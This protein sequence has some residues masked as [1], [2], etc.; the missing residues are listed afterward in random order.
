[1]QQNTS[2]AYDELCKRLK[3]VSS[4]K[5][6]DGLLQ[7]DEMVMMPPGAAASRGAQKSALSGVIYDKRTDK[8]VGALLEQLKNVDVSKELGQVA[9]AVVRDAAED[10]H[11]EVAVPKDLVLKA[12]EL[13]TTAY[14]AWV[15]ARQ[16]SDWS[17]FAPS[18][19][20]WVELLREKAAAIDPSKPV[21]DV[22][23]VEYEKGMSSA[24]LDEIFTQVRDGLIPLL[25]DIKAR[26]AKIDASWV[27]GE[28]DQEAQGKLCQKIALDLGFSTET[29][30][31]DVSVHPFTGGAHPSDV[32]MTTRYSKDNVMEAITGTIHETGH[33]LY[34]QGRNLEYDG[35][36]V[37][38][39]MGMGVH[40]SQSLLWERMVGLSPAFMHYLLKQLAATF[41]SKF[42]AATPES[43]YEAANQ[44]LFP[45]YIRVEADEVTYPMHIIIRY[46]IERQLLDGSIK[47]DDVPKLWNEKMEHYLGS[48]PP[49][50]A[51]G[52]LQD[53]H[54]SMGALGYFPTYSL[55]AMYAV[56]IFQAAS[57][58]I[59]DLDA[60]IVAGEFAPLKA[61]LNE[62]IHK[63]G[64]LYASGDELMTVVTGKPLD[65]A[66]FLEYLR[67]K[68]TQ[69]Y[70]L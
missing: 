57:N 37:N 53:I 4:L 29:G 7:W 25:A 65:P 70:K 54:W 51:K 59:P 45:S 31:L 50:D 24:R 34:E 14:A 36:P 20:Q 39:A 26:G 18:L 56:Q 3:D 27:V 16:A 2:K 13:G 68:Y 6:I 28:Y 44:V 9:A 60:K 46:E 1:M 30:R 8:E 58:D 35:L 32:R 40:E 42:G 17:L 21:Y 15:K 47:V 19:Q 52:C 69:L 33:A 66:V 48:T 38:S 55:G 41:P 64:C 63:V 67:N 23:L 12:A 5:G 49:S 22:L 61:W 43:L 62:K 11:R 10:Y